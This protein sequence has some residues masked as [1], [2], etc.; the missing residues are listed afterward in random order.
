[1]NIAPIDY[2]SDLNK[3]LGLDV[4][5]IDRVINYHLPKEL[6][7][8]LHRAGRTARA[9]QQGTVINLV[10]NRNKNLINRISERGSTI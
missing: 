2:A 3:T 1:A 8:Y 7:N 10:T 6:K 9:G 5:N 4:D